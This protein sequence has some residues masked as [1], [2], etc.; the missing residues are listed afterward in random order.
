MENGPSLLLEDLSE[1]SSGGFA[2]LQ[3][4]GQKRLHNNSQAAV[5]IRQP[6]PVWVLRSLPQG[7]EQQRGANANVSGELS[8]RRA[9]SR[10]LPPAVSWDRPWT[11]LQHK[12]VASDCEVLFCSVSRVII[13]SPVR[14]EPGFHQISPMSVTFRR[15][16]VGEKC[17]FGREDKAN[18][19]KG[20]Q[21]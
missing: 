14:E 9:S 13:Y 11:S 10:Q 2:G 1:R 6:P 15:F 4:E 7:P 3:S 19:S 17:V 20:R 12:V 18:A 16:M 5:E 8:T 21:P